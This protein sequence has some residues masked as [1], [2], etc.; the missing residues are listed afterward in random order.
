[1]L[2]PTFLVLVSFSLETLFLGNEVQ[3]PPCGFQKNKYERHFGPIP[4]TIALL[5]WASLLAQTVKNP[6]AMQQTLVF[7]VQP[8]QYML[9]HFLI[10]Q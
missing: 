6:P 9:K 1:M 4:F 2:S 8:S 10:K 5:S 3:S 7:N